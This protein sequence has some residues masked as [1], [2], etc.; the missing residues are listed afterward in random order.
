VKGGEAA[1]QGRC[2]PGVS[3][4]GFRRLE[5]VCRYGVRIDATPGTQDVFNTLELESL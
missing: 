3:Y 1:S 2:I 4:S 5:I